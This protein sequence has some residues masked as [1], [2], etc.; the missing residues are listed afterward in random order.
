MT[1][2]HHGANGHISYYNGERLDRE[3][4][5][6][7]FLSAMNCVENMLI[8]A[9][10]NTEMPIEDLGQLFSM[11]NAE[12]RAVVVPSRLAVNDEVDDP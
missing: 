2:R 1:S 5:A 8:R 6:N 11:L 9:E 3:S 4:R 10:V 7:R 12:A